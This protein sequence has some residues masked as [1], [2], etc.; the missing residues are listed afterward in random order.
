MFTLLSYFM[1]TLLFLVYTT[2]AR[3]PLPTSIIHL[4][5]YIALS[6]CLVLG[7]TL[8]HLIFLAHKTFKQALSEESLCFRLTNPIESL[9]LYL[10]FKPL[11]K[12]SKRK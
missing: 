1:P 12:K 9:F 5:I 2:T 11:P 3:S 4:K 10:T 7:I 8:T 6:S